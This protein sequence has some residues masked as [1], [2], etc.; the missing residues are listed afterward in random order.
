MSEVNLIRMRSGTKGKVVQIRGGHHMRMKMETLGIRIGCEI[1]KVSGH[2]LGGP[3]V[4]KFGAT[5]A[6]VG[7]GMAHRII[8][9]VEDT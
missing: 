5:R 8:V 4:V 7:H 6:A 2:A 3:V 9:E 1:E